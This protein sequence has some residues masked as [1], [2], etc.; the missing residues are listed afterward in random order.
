M[1]LPNQTKHSLRPVIIFH[2]QTFVFFSQLWTPFSSMAMFRPF[3]TRMLTPSITRRQAAACISQ[4]TSLWNRRPL[5]IDDDQLESFQLKQ[6]DSNRAR[7]T[8]EEPAW[9]GGDYGE[10]DGHGVAQ[11]DSL[12]TQQKRDGPSERSINQVILM[13]RVGTDPQIRGKEDRPITTFSLATN[14]VWKT[15]NPGPG[16]SG[17]QSRVDWHNVAVFKPGLRESTY[18]NVHKGARVHITGR[19]LYGE[20]VDKAGIRRTTTTIACEDIIYLARKM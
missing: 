4:G 9:G 2:L 12:H 6:T 11:R 10:G 18:S 17:W 16:D 20:V 1:F 5:D 8:P 14:S 3:M 13:G 19:L 15:Q 7:Q